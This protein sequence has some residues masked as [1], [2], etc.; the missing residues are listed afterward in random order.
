MVVSALLTVWDTTLDWLVLKL[1][2]PLYVAVSDFAPAGVGERLQE[3]TKLLLIDPVQ[4]VVP[5]LTVTV[6]VGAVGVVPVLDDTAKFTSNGCP[7]TVVLSD[8]DVMLV[9]VP[10]LLMV[11]LPAAAP[12]STVAVALPAPAALAVNVAVAVPLDWM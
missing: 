9:L 4:L 8:C 1:R 5:S 7:V 3:P 6:P 10:A 2:S 11:M 12:L